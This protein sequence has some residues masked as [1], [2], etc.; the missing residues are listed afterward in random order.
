MF[1]HMMLLKQLLIFC[2][3]IGLAIAS[4][5][6]SIL[7]VEP[8]MSTS[9]HLWA[10]TLVK[11][12]LRRGHHIH[13]VSIHEANIEGQLAQNL[14][15]AVFE[16]VMEQI[17]ED[18]DYNPAEWEQ[19]SVLY[20]AYF[21]YNWGFLSCEMAI[22]TKAAEKLQEMI[23][24]VEFDVII[25]DVTL[26][27]C[28]YSLWEI[29]KGR[30]PVVGYI[31]FGPAPWFKDYIGDF[32][33]P[34]IR[35]YT[36]AA[37]AK[38]TGIWQ[39]TWNAL[40]YVVDDLIRHYYYL[41]NQQR[42]AEQYVGHEIR[43]LHEIEKNI[44]IVLINTH[45]SFESAIPL[46][47]N[48]LEIGGIHAQKVQPIPGEVPVTI[49]ENIRKF[50][51]G[52]EN[53]AIA[54]SLGT[55]VQWKAIDMDKLKTVAL[56]L[57]KLKQR[58]LWKLDIEVPFQMADNVMTVKWMPQDKVLT[59][60]NIKAIW[61]HGGLL[62]TQEAIWKGVPII[63]MPFFM[64]QK[65]NV[66]ILVTKGVGVYLDVKTLSTE[67]ILSAIEKVLYDESYT[68]NMKR[69]SRE[70]RDRPVPPLDLAIWSIEYA[71]RHPNGSLA[72]P[73]RSQSWVEKNLIDIYAFVLLNLI[74]ITSV[75]FFVTKTLYKFYYNY[76]YTASKLRKSK[77]S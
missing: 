47:P 37:I 23:K 30:P 64:D 29:A 45:S 25:Q 21:T 48:A 11:G 52:A 15:Y 6:L 5:P 68:K 12:L 7:L 32:H 54:I 27:Q 46:P 74:I 50:L 19:Y 69:L 9:H 73:M 39:R 67:I 66:D 13:V 26:N 61:T 60:K 44:S 77:Q 58:V 4:K 65:C 56:A 49:P 63:G 16:G 36:H 1:L 43:P 76:V 59:H 22:K 57:S 75:T 20:T 3:L 31:P 18:V 62:S 70:F 51:D 33:Y 35:P 41:P 17:T 53:G 38:P 24:N 42:L 14:T 40:Y 2:V 10:M 71:V 72:S 34:T 28:L 8:I 55:N